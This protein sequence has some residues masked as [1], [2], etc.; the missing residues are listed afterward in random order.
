MHRL[1]DAIVASKLLEMTLVLLIDD[2]PLIADIVSTSLGNGGYT[3]GILSNGRSA[4]EVVEFKRPALVILDCAMPHVPGIEVLRQIRAS[5]TCFSVPILML[6]G[7][8]RPS[9]RDI[10]MRAGATSYMSKPFEV[11][12][13]VLRVDDLIVERRQSYSRPPRRFSAR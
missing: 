9:D 5:R 13:L 2:D 6:T 1:G 11:D 12:R 4:L 7:R 8:D 10:A 3:V